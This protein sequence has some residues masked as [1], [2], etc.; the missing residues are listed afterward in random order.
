MSSAGAEDLSGKVFNADGSPARAADVYLLIASDGAKPVEPQVTK[1]DANGS[2]RLEQPAGAEQ[3]HVLVIS[4]DGG[5]VGFTSF[6]TKHPPEV[7]L[8][9][10]TLELTVPLLDPTGKPAVD[11]PVRIRVLGGPPRAGES[12]NAFLFVPAFAHPPLSGKTDAHGLIQFRGLP[13][14]GSVQL[15]VEDDRYAQLTWENRILLPRQSQVRAD[16]IKLQAGASISGHVRFGPTG[17][18]A[19]AVRVAAQ[20]HQDSATQG[21]GEAVTDADGVYHMHRL[22]PGKY[23]VALDLKGD[24]GK[25]WTA[26]A[27]EGLDLKA[28]E[29]RDGVDFELIEG[30]LITGRVVGDGGEPIPNVPIGVYGP[31]HPKT[32]GWVQSSNTAADGT[33]TLRVPGGA[34]DVYIQSG[35]PPSGYQMPQDKSQTTTVQDGKTASVEF[36]LAKAAPSAMVKGK[37]TGP[38]GNPIEGAAIDLLSNRETFMTG[39]GALQSAADGTFETS[40]PTNARD[41]VRLRARKGNLATR[42][43]AAIKP[44]QTQVELKLEANVLASIAGRVVD[45]RGQPVAGAAI[46]LSEMTSMYGYGRE[47]GITGDDGKFEIDQLF[48]DGVYN[49]SASMKGWGQSSIAGKLSLR[50]GEQTVQDDLVLRKRDAL[51]A[52]I[53]LDDDGNPVKG[54]R[55]QISGKATGTDMKTTD[56]EGKFRDEVVAGDELRIYVSITDGRTITKIVKSGDDHIVLDPM[57][58]AK[59][60]R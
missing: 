31:A 52:G 43:A 45:G 17:K 51:I 3:G 35:E 15:N 12:Q 41:K 30:A 28:G 5:A 26:R 29:S 9:A 27:V 50:P 42:G 37:V 53:L 57:S 21:W 22:G 54:Q 16:P 18:P 8:P 40:A 48:A 20:S 2:F 6:S 13:P 46:Q 4:A 33:F 11:V 44:G 38:D 58:D 24:W 23:N 32:S 10:A 14:A 7:H 36:R 49:V 55:L 56:D 34:Q 60:G 1:T 59:A 47:V 39:I 25:S 19:A